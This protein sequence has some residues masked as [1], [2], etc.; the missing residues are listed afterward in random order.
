MTKDVVAY[1][2]S[3]FAGDTQS[4]EIRKDEWLAAKAELIA[5]R[6]GL[7]AE[8]VANATESLLQKVASRLRAT[9][10]PKENPQWTPEE[11]ERAMKQWSGIPL[12]S[13]CFR[14]QLYC[15]CAIKSALNRT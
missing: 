15:A 10:E 2:D 14:P 8:Q 6:H 7:T 12:C 1:L 9:D 11:I 13:V 3:L 4:V 5:R